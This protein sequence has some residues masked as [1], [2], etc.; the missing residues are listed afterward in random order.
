MKAMLANLTNKAMKLNQRQRATLARRLL[1]SL[2]GPTAP[3][4]ESSPEFMA[5]LERRSLEID[6]GKVRCRPADEVFAEL[7]RRRTARRT[8]R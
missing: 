3:V 8:R 1:H 5:E 2:G 7:R 6:Q 4:D